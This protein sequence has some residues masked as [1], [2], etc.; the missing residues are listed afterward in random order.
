MQAAGIMLPATSETEGFRKEAEK[1]N[2]KFLQPEASVCFEFQTGKI[3]GDELL[4][5]IAKLNQD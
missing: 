5:L 4:S 1:G 2:I 3:I